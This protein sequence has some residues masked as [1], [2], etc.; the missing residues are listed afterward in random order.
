MVERNGRAQNNPGVVIDDRKQVALTAGSAVSGISSLVR[1]IKFAHAVRT[2]CSL[3]YGS[4]HC[5]RI[6]EDRQGRR[7]SLLARRSPGAATGSRR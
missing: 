6:D 5:Q 4:S 1:S 7:P 3:G 2:F